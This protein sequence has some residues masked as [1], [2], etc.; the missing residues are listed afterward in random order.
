MAQGV[1]C[2][3]GGGAWCVY[4]RERFIDLPDLG[5]DAVLDCLGDLDSCL[6]SAAGIVTTHLTM[7]YYICLVRFDNASFSGEGVRAK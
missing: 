7:M 4:A 2:G 1:A 5:D 3:D 6:P